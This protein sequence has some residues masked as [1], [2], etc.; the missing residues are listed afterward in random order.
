[1]RLAWCT[2]KACR[3]RVQA[4]PHMESTMRISNATR[5]S[6]WLTV[7]AS[8]A[9][10]SAHAGYFQ[11]RNI[12]SAPNPTPYDVLGIY[13]VESRSLNEQGQV[14]LKLSLTENGTVSD[15]VVERSSGSPRLDDAAVKYVMTHWSYEPP[16]G[17][18]MPAEMLFTVTFVLR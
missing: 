18:K 16:D 5:F 3:H 13:P 1:M 10:P 4:Q 7:L 6:F 12:G 11:G 9:D 2:A 14:G 15:A 8:A 17:Q